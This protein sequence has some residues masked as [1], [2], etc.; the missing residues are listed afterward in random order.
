MPNRITEAPDNVFGT[1]TKAPLKGHSGFL[2]PDAPLG[3]RETLARVMY[4]TGMTR[5]MRGAS[6]RYHGELVTGTRWPRWQKV[7]SPKFLILC[8]HRVG[9]GGI[10]FYSELLPSAF[11]QQMCHLRKNYRVISLDQLCREL[12]DPVADH[13]VVV[14]FDDGYRDVF[15]HAYP[16]LQKYQIPATVF[17]IAN[18]METGQVAWYDRVFLS[19]QVLPAEVL[20]LELDQTR[21]FRFVS[22]QERYRAALEIVIRLRTLPNWR[23]KECCADLERRVTLPKAE[24]ADRMLNWEQVRTMCS[25]GIAFGAHTLTHPVVSRLTLHE[26]E[27]ELG[28]SRKILEANLGRPVLDFAFPFG[29]LDD[30]GFEAQA[31][32]G[33]FGYRSAVTTVPGLNSPGVSP[34][35]LRR[36]QIGQEPSLA[37]FALRMSQAFLFSEQS[38]PSVGTKSS[39]QSH[40]VTVVN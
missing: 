15:T 6:K 24:L 12:Q 40:E 17:L 35:A 19:L 20:S 8:Y 38:E 13:G 22:I 2:I 10:P 34:F 30:C 32:L 21:H 31:Q 14:T 36:I 26:L 27:K 39:R 1:D 18:S 33:R 25:N 9:M 28:E 7:N 3:W 4:R 5:L 23:R 11:D 29:G 37:M 16:V